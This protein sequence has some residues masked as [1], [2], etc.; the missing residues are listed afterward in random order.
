MAQ[1]DSL[2]TVAVATAGPGALA[3]P[4]TGTRHAWTGNYERGSGFPPF[5]TSGSSHNNTSLKYQQRANERAGFT[6]KTFVDDFVA[7][8]WWSFNILQL[9]VVLDTGFRARQC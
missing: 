9:V 8:C 5:T 2:L 7:S 3:R 1:L 6:I 4:S